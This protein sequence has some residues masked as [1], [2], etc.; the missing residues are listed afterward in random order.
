MIRVTILGCGGSL[1]VPLSNGSWGECDP[2]NP[3]NRRRRPSILIE[4]SDGT[5]VLVDTGPD[6]R[7]QLLDAAPSRIDAVIY[8]HSHADHIHGMDD[9]RPFWI[10]RD[11]PIAAY[12]DEATCRDL[13]H[14]FGY[15]VDTVTMERGLY[16]PILGLKR[17]P[18]DGHSRIAGM[19]FTVFL[20][21]HHSVQTLGFRVGNFAYSTDVAHLPEHAFDLLDG[22]H[23]W[24]VD[25]CREAPHPSHAHL[26]RTLGWID[27]LRPER[28]LLTHMNHTMDYSRLRAKLPTG[29]EP[30]YDGLVLECP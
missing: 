17:L 14:R 2:A 15:A 19:D 21:D 16:T 11:E 26:D 25:A 13:E 23:T 8:T 10:G 7:Q 18:D 6:L 1:G 20:Q 27:R 9:L 4:A 28:A 12:A 24:V 30:G 3:R 5:T 29:V 22:I